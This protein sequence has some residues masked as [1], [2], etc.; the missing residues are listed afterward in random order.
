MGAAKC[1]HR[2]ARRKK[3][4]IMCSNQQIKQ[5]EHRQ[6][7]SQHSRNRRH[8]RHKKHKKERKTI[9]KNC[10]HQTMNQ[11]SEHQPPNAS[12]HVYLTLHAELD[13]P[14]YPRKRGELKKPH[15]HHAHMNPSNQPPTT[16]KNNS[17]MKKQL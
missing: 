15:A 1:R 14:K 7:K 12:S 13:A 6:S 2:G 4:A 17:S 8:K 10:R 9:M 11:H 5:R 16:K 3:K